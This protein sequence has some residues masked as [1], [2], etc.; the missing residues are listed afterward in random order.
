MKAGTNTITG[1]MATDKTQPECPQPRQ[2][3]CQAN[4]LSSATPGTFPHT[5]AD[6]HRTLRQPWHQALT[7][8]WHKRAPAKQDQ[9]EH[10]AQKVKFAGSA[11]LRTQATI[12]TPRSVN[13]T[14]GL[15]VTVLIKGEP[16]LLC[17]T[18]IVAQCSSSL[19][20]STNNS[21]RLATNTA[22]HYLLTVAFN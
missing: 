5:H 4:E 17:L 13:S 8:T 10:A 3:Q 18:K 19:T 7:Q 2:V 15:S 14:S 11:P 12:L 1:Q 6:T 16:V 20:V 22:Y 21:N 9:P